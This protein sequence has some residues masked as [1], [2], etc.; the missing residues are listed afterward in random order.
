[1]ICVVDLAIMWHDVLVYSTH[2]YYNSSYRRTMV[3]LSHVVLECGGSDVDVGN[4]RGAGC[5]WVV[6]EP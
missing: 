4:R 6:K 2:K 3:Y 1:M 5:K